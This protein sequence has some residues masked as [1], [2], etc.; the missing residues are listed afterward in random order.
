MTNAR[1]LLGWTQGYHTI[2]R[3]E[4]NVAAMLYHL[5]MHGP[6]LKAFLDLAGCKLPVVDDQVGVY[7]EYA[8]L[9]DLWNERVRDRPEVGRSL[10]LDML[11]PNNAD[12]LARMSVVEF[13]RFFGAVPQP[14]RDFIQSPGNWS[15]DRFAAHVANHA[16]FLRICRFKWAFNAKPDLVIHVSNDAA[17]CVEAKFKSGEGHYP[18]KQTEKTEF[19]RRGL[20]LQGQTDVQTYILRDLLGLS[21]EFIFLVEDA[22]ATSVTHRTLTWR[23]VFA[24]LDTSTCPAFMQRWFTRFA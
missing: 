18:S 6:N 10:I 12:D 15:I 23:E 11:R 9:R 24:T 20:S 8:F 13:N 3:E 7:F 14:S 4:R 21:A 16:E 22:Q 5:L 19:V 17:L 1:A 2:C